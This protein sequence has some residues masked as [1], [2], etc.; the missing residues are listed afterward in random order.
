MLANGTLTVVRY[1]DE[2]LNVR[3]YASAMGL[4]FLLVQDNARPHVARVCRQFLDDEDAI[5][6]PSRSP[7]LNTIENLLEIM[8]Q[9]IRRHRIA[10]QTAPGAH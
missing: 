9:C 1:R 10:P 3:P 6:R 5:D 4:G 2:I 8:Y 7:D